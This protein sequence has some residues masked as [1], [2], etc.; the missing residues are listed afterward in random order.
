[1]K[2]AHPWPRALV[3][4]GL[5][6]ALALPTWNCA[7]AGEKPRPKVLL[8]GIDAAD[9]EVMG[10]LL[11]QG[12]LAAR[13][14]WMEPIPIRVLPPARAEASS[15]YRR[16]TP[17]VRGTIVSRYEAMIEAIGLRI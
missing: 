13:A 14:R 8:I 12:K 3:I 9:W 11:D 7:R 6:A 15:L 5:G 16:P 1:M 4:A 17:Q 2:R 10:P